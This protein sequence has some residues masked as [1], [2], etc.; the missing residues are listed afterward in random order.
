MGM[1]G[2]RHA[3]GALLPGDSDQYPLYRKLG[4]HQDLSGR[5]RRISTS[6]GVWTSD[7]LAC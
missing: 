5:G 3:P 1:G 4:G 6:L 7:R 2:Q